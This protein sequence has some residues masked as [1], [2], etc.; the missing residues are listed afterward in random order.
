MIWARSAA[1]RITAST[2]RR[3]AL[4]GHGSFLTSNSFGRHYSPA[5]KLHHASRVEH[6]RQIGRFWPRFLRAAAIDR[7]GQCDQHRNPL[8]ARW[9]PWPLFFAVAKSTALYL[10]TILKNCLKTRPNTAHVSCE[11][12]KHGGPAVYSIPGPLICAQHGEGED[13]SNLR[14]TSSNRGRDGSGI[15]G[16]RRWPRA[17]IAQCRVGRSA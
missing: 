13:R 8:S 16:H 15:S 17:A 6:A 4:V 5:R 11:F 9:P 3:E 1:G 7:S 2:A 10:A 14:R 12:W